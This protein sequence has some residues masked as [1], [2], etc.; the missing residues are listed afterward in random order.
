MKF[1]IERENQTIKKFNS[2]KKQTKMKDI[3]NRQ[4]IENLV[5]RFYQTV[6]QDEV[7]GHFFTSVV[8]LSWEKHI[9]IM[10]SFWATLLLDVPIYKGNPMAK[11]FDLHKLAPIEARHFEQWLLLWKETVNENFEGEK[12]TEAISRATA[13]AGMIQHKINQLDKI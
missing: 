3:T 4:D 13:I 6:I 5:D 11:H 10:Y 7:I 8:L 12:A 1:I 2:L 9:P